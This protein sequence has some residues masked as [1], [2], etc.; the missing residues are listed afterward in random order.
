V[1]LSL[2]LK[3]AG[4]SLLFLG[5]A[6]AL[7]PRRFNWKAELGAVSLLNRQIFQVHCFFIGLIVCMFGLLALV[8]TDALLERTAL[9]PVVLAGIVLF[10]LARLIVQFFVY[11]PTLW[12]GDRFNTRIH[13][14]FSLLWT[15]YVAI[16][17]WALWEQ[18]QPR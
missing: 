14:L 13:L 4:A 17:G 16:F 10:W 3:I 15:Y 18:L 6:H 8:F 2:H 9:A 11:D 1:S 5:L 7:F 12:R